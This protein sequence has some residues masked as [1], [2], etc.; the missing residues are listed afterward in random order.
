MTHR[1]TVQTDFRQYHINSD[2][3]KKVLNSCLFH[4]KANINH[5]KAWS[6]IA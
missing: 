3:P 4:I 2:V 6:K 1:V 5:L